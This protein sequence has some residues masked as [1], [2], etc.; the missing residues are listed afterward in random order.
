MIVKMKYLNLGAGGARIHEEGWINLDDLHS[1]LAP[2]TPERDALDREQNYVNHDVSSGLLPF[3][4]D[5]FDGILASH[6]FEHFDAQ[7][8]VRI[9]RECKRVLKPG[10][11]L[12]VSVPDASYFRKVYP[13]D[14]VENW[15]RLYEVTDPN[16]T[17][18]TFFEAALFFEQH[19][20]V[21]TEDSLWCLFTRGG[22][23]I[24]G[25]CVGAPEMVK[26]LNRLPFSLVMSA[27][28]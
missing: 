11:G 22:F 19:K 25:L 17:I 12:L 21:L 7:E 3:G 18:P 26:H 1:Q 5:E 10:G 15:P 20:Q 14:C 27:V 4:N 2:G 23:E 8:A 16:N 13:E 9:I 6:F 28:K 24:R